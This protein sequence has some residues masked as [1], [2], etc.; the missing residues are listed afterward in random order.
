MTAGNIY[1]FMFFL[2]EIFP[3]SRLLGAV[4]SPKV[5]DSMIIRDNSSPGGK[6][7]SKVLRKMLNAVAFN[8]ALKTVGKN[9]E[10]TSSKPCNFSTMQN[11]RMQCE[12]T[13]GLHRSKRI[14][15]AAR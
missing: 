15:A 9:S 4:L 8:T 2:R 11:I 10:N 5:N 13:E 12:L 7:V 3:L 1:Y 14:E 6:D